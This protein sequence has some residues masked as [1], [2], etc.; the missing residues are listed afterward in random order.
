MALDLLNAILLIQI[1]SNQFDVIVKAGAA[2]HV[3]APERHMNISKIVSYCC[4]GIGVGVQ[5][6]IEGIRFTT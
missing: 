4:G 2:Q 3:I 1:S 6:G 5:G